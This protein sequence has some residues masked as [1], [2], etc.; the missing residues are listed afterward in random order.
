MHGLC[1]SVE[2]LEGDGQ[3]TCKVELKP[4]Y[5]WRKQGYKSFIVDGKPVDIFWDV[6]AAKFNGKREP[7]QSTM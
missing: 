6:K 7:S 1:V 2:G 4:W 3:Y 5:F